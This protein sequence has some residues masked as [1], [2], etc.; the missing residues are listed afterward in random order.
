MGGVMGGGAIQLPGPYTGDAAWAGNH[1]SELTARRGGLEETLPLFSLPETRGASTIEGQNGEGE[2]DGLAWTKKP[3]QIISRA[4][5]LQTTLRRLVVRLSRKWVYLVVLVVLFGIGGYFY[6]T[7]SDIYAVWIPDL[8]SIAFSKKPLPPPLNRTQIT[9]YEL[10]LRTEG[11]NIVDSQGRRFKL[12][13]INWYGASDELFVPGGL[14]IQHRKVIAQTIKKMGF[15]SVRLPYADELVTQNP[16][17]DSRLVKANPDLA[18]LRALDIFE[19]VTSTLT[20]AGIAVIINNHITRATW[21]CGANP[22]DAAW[23]NDYLMGLCKVTQSEDQW[24]QNWETV[25]Q[26][27]TNNSLVIGADLRNEVRGLWGTMSWYKWARAAE[28]AGNR[29]LQLNPR[30]LIVVEGTESANDLSGARNRPVKLDV[31]NRLVYSAHV[32]AWSGWGSFGGRFSKRSYSSFVESMHSH[33][34]YLL[35][36]DIAPVWVGE[37]GAPK[38]PV[39]GDATYWRNLWRYLKSV[40][41]DFGYWA[42]NPRKPAGNESES[43][44]VVGDDW[45][46][47]VLD[48]RMRDMVQLMRM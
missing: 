47:V 11:R 9:S 19:A 48:Y 5:A 31:P 41:A 18:G 24:I 4:A 17:I 35:E 29:L 2:L 6:T 44:A 36:D 23:S 25:M 34:G 20:D 40:D 38:N 1:Q 42:L 13:S 26:R 39:V 37:V 3:G 43:Y 14:D 10:P 15:N 30:W 33:W 46:D 8:D 32:Y 27:F 7:E 45:V 12:A 16:F 22:C 28:R 21:C